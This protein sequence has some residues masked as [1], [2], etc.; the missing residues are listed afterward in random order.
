MPE[1]LGPR[2]ILFDLDMTLVETR[3]DIAI[4]AN[5]VR[6]GFGLEPLSIADL[7]PMIGDGVRML[8]ERALGP[9]GAG[10]Q[11]EAL[12][13]FR[14]HYARHCL[15]RS[16]VYEGIPEL[17][18]SL[19]SRPKAVVSNKPEAFCWQV[20][21]GVG[22]AE[23][24]AV[25]IGGDSLD[26]LKPDPAPLV[27][28]SERLGVPAAACV[29]VGDTWRDVRAGRLAGC[30]VVAVTYGLGSRERLL[31]ER[32]DALVDHPSEIGAWIE[33]WSR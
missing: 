26:A 25:V 6:A 15:D 21:R 8:L 16:Y 13:R 33:R 22:I 9:A 17:L 30:R 11:D 5:A 20:L 29:M 24:F 12:A 1:K 14:E 23:A 3:E 32:P 7:V 2:A 27:A 10:R 19:A 18:A 4:S 28:A 31:E